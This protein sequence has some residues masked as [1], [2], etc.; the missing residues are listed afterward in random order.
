MTENELWS[1]VCQKRNSSGGQR[2]GRGSGRERQVAKPQRRQEVSTVER[3]GRGPSAR[4]KQN[5]R[6]LAK[7]AVG[8]N[9]DEELFVFF[10]LFLTIAL[11]AKLAVL[12]SFHATF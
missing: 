4:Q 11:F 7:P 3:C 9:C 1:A 6:L 8:E 5:G 12:A 10:L 2:F